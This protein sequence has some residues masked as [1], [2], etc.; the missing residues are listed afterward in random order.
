MLLLDKTCADGGIN[1]Q[2]AGRTIAQRMDAKSDEDASRARALSSFSLRCVTP[3]RRACERERAFG[4]L[5][6][7]CAAQAAEV[8]AEMSRERAAREHAEASV[9]G[10]LEEL[11][12]RMRAELEAERRD[13]EVTEETMLRL[14]ETAVMRVG[15]ACVGGARSPPLPLTLPPPPASTPPLHRPDAGAPL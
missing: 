7:G 3:P 8:R 11:C 14:L 4:E 12:G 6:A 13:R 15:R 5:L 1:L 10:M 9:L 2:A